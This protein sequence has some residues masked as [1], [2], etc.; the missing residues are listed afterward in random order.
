MQPRAQR[1]QAAS[2]DVAGT[3]LQIGGAPLDTHDSVGADADLDRLLAARDADFR[4]HAPAAG[5]TW[6]STEPAKL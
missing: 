4:K 2:E 5:R 1:V 3:P 6:A